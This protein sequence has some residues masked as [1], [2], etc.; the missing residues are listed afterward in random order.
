[1][2]TRIA[3]IAAFIAAACSA[4]AV[5]IVSQNRYIDLLAVA[6]G[7]LPPVG[8]TSSFRAD[9]SDFGPFDVTRSIFAFSPTN[10]NQQGGAS[11]EQHS[12]I[13]ADL[14]TASGNVGS[15]TT[16]F[17]P[18]SYGV[19]INHYELVFDVVV[20]TPFLLSGSW[21]FD[22]Q[23]FYGPGS[24]TLSLTGPGVAIAD[25]ISTRGTFPLSASGDLMPGRYAF[26]LDFQGN[27]LT[28]VAPSMRGAF[29]ATLDFTIPAP[30]TI[31]LLAIGGLVGM[32][33][34]PPRH[35]LDIA[36]V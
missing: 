22:P 16:T 3:S 2:I 35:V 26:A 8:A 17:P 29:D 30:G 15:G 25:S 31:G 9:A 36:R 18:S 19:A 24:G 32:R 28:S 33:R 1:M 14:L 4:N 34:R 13:T 6:N 27:L 10:P 5:T 7:G 12:T 21:A 23:T 20:P 11:A